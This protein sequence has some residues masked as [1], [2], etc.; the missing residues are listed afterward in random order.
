L[1]G[2]EQA[3]PAGAAF[4]APARQPGASTSPVPAGGAVYRDDD[5]EFVVAEGL[6]NVGNKSFYR[7]AADRRWVDSTVTEEMEGQA[8]RVVQFSD[9][10]FQLAQQHGKRLAR[11]LVFDEPVLLNLDGQAYMIDPPETP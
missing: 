2:A 11:Y 7:R 10:Y 3:A 5:D 8:Q 6:R 1:S 4:G 9:E